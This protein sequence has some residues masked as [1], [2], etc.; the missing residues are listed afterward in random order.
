[1]AG[2]LNRVMIIGNVGKDPEV[3]TF[4]DGGKVANI[5]VACTDKWKSKSGEKMERTEWVR[6]AI[7]GPLADVVERYVKKGSKLYLS[8]ALQT[9]KYTDKDGVEKY[10]TEVVLQGYGAELIMLDGKRDDGPAYGS[11]R[12]GRSDDVKEDEIPW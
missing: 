11:Q 9:R 12:D 7:F 5:S 2:S 6:V 8:G 10:S 3:R 1:M 4:G